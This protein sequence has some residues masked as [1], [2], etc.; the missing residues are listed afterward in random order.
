M[1]PPIARNDA[2]ARMSLANLATF[3]EELRAVVGDEKRG[4]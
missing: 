3:A 2:S 1:H 4:R